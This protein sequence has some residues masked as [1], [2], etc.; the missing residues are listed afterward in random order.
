M[1]VDV[2][3]S[4]TVA[5]H[6]YK[7]SGIII[8]CFQASIDGLVPTITSI[9]ATYTCIAIAATIKAC[10]ILHSF[11]LMKSCWLEKAEERPT[12]HEIVTTISTCLE[13]VTGYLDL[14][15]PTEK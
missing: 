3:K 12:F 2:P 9:V 7:S 13:G 4:G 1:Y 11:E 14:I 15:S 6:Y 5:E 10:S 8:R